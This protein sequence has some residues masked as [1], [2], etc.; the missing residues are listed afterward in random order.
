[1]IPK[2]V[3]DIRVWCVLFG[4]SCSRDLSYSP[5]KHNPFMALCS[6]CDHS[7]F[8]NSTLQPLNWHT[9][10]PRGLTWTYPHHTYLNTHTQAPPNAP[11]PTHSCSEIGLRANMRIVSIWQDSVCL[12]EAGRQVENCYGL[13]DIY[14]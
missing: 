6:G 12:D 3:G 11:P 8:A 13:N 9:S 5:S 2:V 10:W 4:D 7:P 1:M 14:A